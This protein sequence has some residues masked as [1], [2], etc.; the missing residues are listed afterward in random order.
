MKEIMEKEKGGLILDAGD[1]FLKK[2][3]ASPPENEIKRLQEKARLFLK[4]CELMGYH[5]IGIGDNDLSLGK[6]F[7]A[8]PSK[9]SHGIIL[10]SNV[11]DEDSGNHFFSVTY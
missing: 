11:I 3:S 2:F 9:T 1:L 5:S 8:K 10:S 7:I 6:K 4:S